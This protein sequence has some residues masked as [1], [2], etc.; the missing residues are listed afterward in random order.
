MGTSTPDTSS[1]CTRTPGERPAPSTAR[2]PAT[3]GVRVLVDEATSSLFATSGRGHRG[4]V[5][6]FPWVRAFRYPLPITARAR[7]FSTDTNPVREGRP[8]SF[9]ALP[10]PGTCRRDRRRASFDGLLPILDSDGPAARPSTPATV[11]A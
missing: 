3:R 2:R 11:G 8:P 6:P 4:T 1:P 5:G 7:L 9:S 10:S